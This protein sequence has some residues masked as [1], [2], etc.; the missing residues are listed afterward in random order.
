MSEP[1]VLGLQA[2]WLIAIGVIIGVSTIVAAVYSFAVRRQ[3]CR[4]VIPLW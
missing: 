2:K 1:T 3:P 4:S